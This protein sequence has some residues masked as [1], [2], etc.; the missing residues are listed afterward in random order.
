MPCM[1]TCGDS[2]SFAVAAFAV[3]ALQ[4]HATYGQSAK[5]NHL[6][7]CQ[8]AWQNGA[9]QAEDP[10]AVC[11]RLLLFIGASSGC[12]YIRFYCRVA[13]LAE[14]LIGPERT[15]SK[16]FGQVQEGW[17]LKY[18]NCIMPWQGRKKGYVLEIRATAAN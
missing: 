12:T 2:P 13:S 15:W 3:H 10:A 16:L 5:P 17:S 7:A 6:A 14:C 9:A 11:L 4:L 18:H 8:Q 1:F